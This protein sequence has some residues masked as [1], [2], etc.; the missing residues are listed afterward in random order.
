MYYSAV[1]LVFQTVL[2]LTDNGLVKITMRTLND[3]AILH[4]LGLATTW[5]GVSV[6]LFALNPEWVVE[7]K[8]LVIALTQVVV[9]ASVGHMTLNYIFLGLMPGAFKSTL[10]RKVPKYYLTVLIILKLATWSGALALVFP[11]Y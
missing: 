10:V 9:L 2:S 8:I 1:L 11:N 7:D 4:R 5:V 6:W 3:A